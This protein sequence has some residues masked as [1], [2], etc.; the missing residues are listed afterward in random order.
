MDHTGQKWGKP[1]PQANSDQIAETIVQLFKFSPAQARNAYSAILLLPGVGGG[2]RFHPLLGPYKKQWNKN[3]ERYASFWDPSPVLQAMAQTPFHILTNNISLLRKHLIV[4]CRLLC[5]Y[6]SHDLANLK[7]T[8][9][10]LDVKI[11]FIKIK[12]KGQTMLKWERVLSL[13]QTPQISPFH[14]IQAYVALTRQYGKMG[15]PVLLALQPPHRPISAD[16]VGSITKTFF[17]IIWYLLKNLG[18]PLHERGRGRLTQKI[19]FKR[20]GGL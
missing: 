12:R 10:I 4:T 6:R 11:P 5:L 16:T 1:P 15:G 13:P 2:I 8:V 20:R 7:R 18:P 14:L 17:G 9:S 19:G 3:M